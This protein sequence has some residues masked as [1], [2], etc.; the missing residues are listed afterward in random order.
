MKLKSILLNNFQGIKELK[1]DFDGKNA[2]I[3]GDNGTGKT[4][5]YNAF[6][7]CLF[8]KPSTDIKNF[9]PKT[10]TPKG[11]M[12]NAEH[13][14]EL[15][16]IQEDESI[17]TF[18]R[19]FKEVYT[20]KRGQAA[21][22]FTGHK[23]EYFIN[24]VPTKEKDFNATVA[25]ICGDAEQQKI[26]TMY[27]YFP[28]VLSWEKRREWLLEIAGDMTDEEIFKKNKSLNKLKDFLAMPNNPSRL[29]SVE[30]YKK[31][32]TAEKANINKQLQGL[33]SRID[34]AQRAI[35]I[36]PK[37]S[38]KGL[39]SRLAETN[40]KLEEIKNNL[41]KEE[42]PAIAE[43][44]SESQ[45]QIRLLMEE[46]QEKRNEQEQQEESTRQ[47]LN[48]KKRELD[49]LNCKINTLFANLQNM[50]NLRKDLLASYNAIQKELFGADAELCPTCG[51]ALPEEEKQKLRAA[52]N[53]RKSE[54]LEEINQQGKEKCSK[55]IIE[56]T[57]KEIA[58]VQACIDKLNK[59]IKELEEQ[60]T[61]F[62]P[63]NDTDIYKEY[64][65]K[66]DNLIAGMKA[67]TPAIDAE[68]VNAFKQE[69]ETLT[70]QKQEIES[71]IANFDFAKKQQQRIEELE[72]EEQKLQKAFEIAEQGL[73]FCDMFICKKVSMLTAKI[74]A[75][76]AKVQFKLFETQIN[77]GLKEVCEVLVP[78]ANDE[79]IPFKDA[80]NAAKIN[81]GLEI[82]NTFGRYFGFTLPVF[83]DNAESVTKVNQIA[84]QVIK[85]VVSKHYQQLT[86][87]VLDND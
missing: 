27:N 49:Q 55:E 6:T 7:W 45:N 44:N 4:T 39:R 32:A 84:A 19:L 68:K 42:H 56:E 41:Y 65:N 63:W 20:K 15:Q 1:L 31:I 22:E 16:L 58:K 48:N 62:L 40:S 21:A 38:E 87:E 77:G 60:Q 83:V 34:E 5:L 33:P 67:D 10:I 35:P 54:K 30:E 8:G 12:H 72:E 76:F 73:Y 71:N 46:M 59:E 47:R 80:N 85:L 81:A 75:Y 74:N 52:F 79:L 14:V 29:Y 23:V 25:Q 3:F 78:A 43:T 13:F 70:E 28:E 57:E 11:E 51:Q 18:K 69:I 37:D 26:L 17:T 86:M 64:K 24:G 61:A 36:L 53:Q 2:N 82:I 50:N 9:S 66:I